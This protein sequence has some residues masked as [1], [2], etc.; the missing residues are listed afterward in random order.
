MAKTVE[1]VM[2]GG[3]ESERK[4]DSEREGTVEAPAL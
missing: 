1:V 2:G 3:K 4:N